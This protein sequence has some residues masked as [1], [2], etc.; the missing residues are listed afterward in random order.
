MG[1]TLHPYIMDNNIPAAIDTVRADPQVYSQAAKAAFEGSKQESAA[2]GGMIGDISLAGSREQAAEQ[3]QQDAFDKQ[4][5]QADKEAQAAQS[6]QDQ[7]YTKYSA[8]AGQGDAQTAIQKAYMNAQP[9]GDLGTDAQQAVD[10]VA[11]NYIDNAPSKEAQLQ[12]GMSF[13]PMRNRAQAAGFKQQVGINTSAAAQS[14]DPL[15]Q[16]ATDTVTQDPNQIDI[17]TQKLQDYVSALKGVNANSPTL[18]N[19]LKQAVGTVQSAGTLAQTDQDPYTALGKV[20]SGTLAYASPTLIQKVTARAQ[21]NINGDVKGTL[22]DLN[23]IKG[24]ILNGEKPPEDSMDTM[25]AAQTSTNKL[26]SALIN[27]G[28]PKLQSFYQGHLNDL[29]DKQ[30]EVSDVMGLQQSLVG[31]GPNDVQAALSRVAVDKANTPATARTDA[32]FKNATILLNQRAKD[33]NNSPYQVEQQDGTLPKNPIPLDN[34]LNDDPNAKAQFIQNAKQAQSAL[35]AKYP[36]NPNAIAVTPSDM[37]N[38]VSQNQG[39]PPTQVLANTQFLSELGPNVTNAFAKAMTAKG[40]NPTPLATAISV[41][42]QDLPMAQKIARGMELMSGPNKQQP[43]ISD[44]ESAPIV[45]RVF[46]GMANNDPSLLRKYTDAANAM[47]ADDMVSGAQSNQKTAFEEN[48]RAVSGIQ[49]IQRTDPLLFG[50]HA[51]FGGAPGY[52]TITPWVP[53]KK[54]D[55]GPAASRMSGDDFYNTIKGLTPQDINSYGNGQPVYPIDGSSPTDISKYKWMPTTGGKYTLVDDTSGH[56]DKSLVT[57]NA[58]GGQK[59][60]SPYEFDMRRYL[61][62]KKGQS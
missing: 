46:G 16:V 7:V 60:G 18:Q 15:T 38:L 40:Q 44:H 21:N 32:A 23:N 42:G 2:F 17:Q 57:D 45:G 3:Q 50:K 14:L 33:L 6:K 48:L 43:I 31:M 58:G 28:N 51:M 62:D 27:S 22:S 47:T 4:Q 39:K 61:S 37:N 41:A 25:N 1:Q 29:A 13:M 34:N 11:K 10:S 59:A 8:L 20:D 36:N 9:G 5:A 55:N 56:G 49:N 26:N 24:S 52:N 12:V 35:S 54:S 30:Q 19:K 53:N